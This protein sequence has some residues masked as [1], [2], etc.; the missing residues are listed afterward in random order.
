MFLFNKRN[1][2][3]NN[4]IEEKDNYIG[5]QNIAYNIDDI[6]EPWLMLLYPRKILDRFPS[7]YTSFQIHEEYQKFI[8]K[9]KYIDQ[10]Q[11]CFRNNIW[12]SN[13]LVTVNN[14]NIIDIV[15][16]NQYNRWEITCN[17][18]IKPFSIIINISIPISSDTFN[19][20]LLH[21]GTKLSAYGQFYASWDHDITMETKCNLYPLKYEIIN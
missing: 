5:F 6:L 10:V 1:K 15:K 11:K 20:G 2:L 17:Y 7:N 9:Y 19:I 4:S 13:L 3:K 8:S 21:R 18:N 14:L 12:P 16:N